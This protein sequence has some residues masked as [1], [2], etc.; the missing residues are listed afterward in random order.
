MKKL[1]KIIRWIVVS[2]F[3]IMALSSLVQGGLLGTLFFLLGGA[4]IA[5]LEIIG[6]CRSKLKLNKILSIILAVFLLFAG[7]LVAPTSETPTDT[8]EDTQISGIVSNDDIEEDT[9]NKKEETA[10]RKEPTTESTESSKPVEITK[11]ETQATAC[12]HANTSIKNKLDATCTDNGYTGDTYCNT[13]SKVIQS[14]SEIKAIGHNTEIRNKKD[15]TTTNE[16]YTGDTY[17]KIC[18]TRIK[19]GEIIPKIVNNT[20]LETNSATVYVTETGKKYHSTKN[21]SGLSRAKAIYS[22]TLQGAKN[23]GLDPCSKCH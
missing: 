23:R 15:A 16:G 9:T 13:C 1:L 3:V 2:I 12:L 8:S 14:G 19:S 21:C 11:N 22:S 17:C 4:I 6:K 20:Q 5:P 10:S 7:A 18:E